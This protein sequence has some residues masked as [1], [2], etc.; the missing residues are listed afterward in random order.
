MAT[1][2]EPAKII[3]EAFAPD[4]TTITARLYDDGTIM[5]YGVR[6]SYMH[7]DKPWKGKNDGPDKPAKYG[8]VGLMPKATHVAAKDLIKKYG[9]K[10]LRENKVDDLA[11]DRKFMRNGDQAGRAEYKGMFT[12]SAREE[13]SPHLRDRSGKKVDQQHVKSVFQSGYWFNM[14]IRPWFQPASSGWGIRLNA[15]LSACQF[16]RQ[17]ETFG[18]G[19]ITDEDVDA[20]FGAIDDG[21]AGFSGSDAGLDDL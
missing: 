3:E 9:E 21:D 10:L 17:D 18:E 14:L 15:G 16:V 4:G 12:I 19:G 13:R 11:A 7:V 5:V 8:M 2:K 6:G 20:R 1:P